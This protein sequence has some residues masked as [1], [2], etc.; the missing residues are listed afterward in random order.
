MNTKQ[1]KWTCAGIVVAAM[2]LALRSLLHYWFHHSL[3]WAVEAGK[4]VLMAV[5]ASKFLPQLSEEKRSS[6]AF[7]AIV[8]MAAVSVLSDVGI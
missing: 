3:F 6:L 5:W 4:I 8:S 7:G 1:M 2:A